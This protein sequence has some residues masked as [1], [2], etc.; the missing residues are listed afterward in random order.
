MT[1]TP[2][3]EID[4]DPPVGT[5]DDKIDTPAAVATH[6]VEPDR[7]SRTGP[8]KT[9]AVV[10]FVDDSVDG[11]GDQEIPQ[12]FSLESLRVFLRWL[13]EQMSP[14]LGAEKDSSGEDDLRGA[15]SRKRLEEAD[16][17]LPNEAIQVSADTSPCGD[18][19]TAEEADVQDLTVEGSNG[20]QEA[21]RYKGCTD[22]YHFLFPA[23]YL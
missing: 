8:G 7:G 3:L 20:A 23:P 19:G 15:R 18:Q 13:A 17:T 2:R 4:P 5:I 12:D 16:P 1:A 10:F 9:P 21:V 6:G 14:G 11:A 22:I